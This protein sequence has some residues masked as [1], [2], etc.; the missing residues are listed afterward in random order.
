VGLPV[1][2]G[3]GL[4]VEDRRSIDEVEARDLEDAAVPPEEP[5]D[6]QPQGVRAVRR[7]RGE[8]AARLRLARRD[9]LELGGSG[10]MEVEEDDDVREAFEAVETGCAFG[11]DLDLTRRSF[12]ETGRRESRRRQV[13]R[14]L[15]ARADDADGP[16]PDA[17][18]HF[19]T[20]VSHFS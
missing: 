16:E 9:D 13:R 3:I 14:F 2:A 17:G 18:P 11:K 20:Y 8:D 5:E 7:P 4:D 15:K 10:P 1:P 6:A 19:P 12:E